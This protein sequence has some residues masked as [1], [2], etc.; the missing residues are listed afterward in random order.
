MLL[1]LHHIAADGWSLGPLGRDLAR[2]YAAR[3]QGAEPQLPALAVQYADYT[4]WQQQVLGSETDPESPLGGQIAFW[5]KALEGLPEQLELPTD[6]PR[7]A[8][9]SYRGETVPLQLGSELHGRLLVLAREHQVSLF[10][11][12]QAALATLL[13]RLGAG[14]DIPIGCPIAGRTDFALEELVGFFVNTLVLRTDTSANPSFRE[15]LARVRSA[16]LAA[17]AHQELPFERLVELLNPA[18]SL[19]RHPLFQVMLAFQNTPEI[20]FE[21]PGIVASLEPVDINVAK[22]DLCFSLGERRAPDGM[23]EGIEG[24][25]EYR[26]DLFERRT[27]EALARR[28]E[29]LLEAVTADP[30]QRIGRLELLGSEERRQILLERNDTACEIPPGT[31]PALFE[32]E[33][34]RSPEATAL[35][36]EE[37]TLTYAQLNTQSNRLAHLLIARGI[38][39]ETIVALVLPRSAEMV[40]GLLAILKAGAAYLPLDPDDPAER[41]AYMLR[42]AQAACVLTTA[43]IAQRLPERVALILLDHPETVGVLLRSQETNPS[44]AERTNSLN[45]NNAAYVIYTSGSTGVPKGVVITHGG[46][47]NYAAWALQAYGLGVGSGAPINTPLAFDATVT[48]LFLPLLSG[49]PITLLPELR[50]FEVLAEEPRYSARFSLLKLTPAH[51]EVLNHLMPDKSLEGLTHCLVIGGESLS[52]LTV[53]RWRRHAPQTRLINEYGPTETAVGC[54]IYEVQPTDPEGGTIPIGR[55]IWN[56]RVYVLDGNLQPVPAGVAGELCIAGAG[57]ARGYLNRPGL[58]AERFVADPFGAPGHRMYRT[59]DLARWRADGVLEFLGRGDQQLKIRGFR[60]EPG[61]IE[62]ALVRHTGVTQAAVIAREDHAGDKRLVGYVVTKPAQSLDRGELRAYLSRVLPDYMVPAVF[63]E[64][65]ALPLTPNGKL[66]RKALP[67]PDFAVLKGRWRAPRSPEEEILCALFSEVLGVSGVGIED[68]FFVLG[69]HSLLATRLISRIRTTLEIELPIRTLFETPTVCGVARSLQASQ[70]AR[71]GLEALPRPAQIPLSFAQRRLWFIDRLEGP[72]PTYNIPLALRLRGRLDFAA[73]KAAL[74]DVVRR[75]ESLRT[76][77]TELGGTPYQRILEPASAEPGL[78]VVPATEG[79]LARGL[80]EAARY[81]FDLGTEIPLRASLFTLEHDEQVLLL[82]VHHIAADGWSMVPLVRDLAQA[83]MARC[84]SKA[85]ELRPLVVQYADYTLWQQ[86]TLGDESDSHS[87]LG[88]QLAYW[89]QTLQALPEQLD[90]PTDRPRPAIASYRGRWVPLNLSPEL[91]SRLLT[92]AYKNQSSLFMVLQAGVSVLLTRLGAGTDIP[93]GTPIAGRTDIGLEE[94]VGFFVNTLVLRTDTSANPS[95]RQL[96]A[97]VRATDLGAYAH[98][99]LP[100]E[101]L[102]ELLNPARSLSRHPLF[103]VMLAFQ[104]NSEPTLELPGIFT[105]SEAVNIDAARFDLT[106]ELTERRA[107]DGTPEGIE[108]A[109]EYRTDLFEGS[110]VQAIAE[111][112]VRLLERAAAEPDRPIGQ[113]DI[114]NPKERQQLLVQWNNTEQPVAK[115]TLSSLFEAQVARSP[116]EPALLFE[117]ITLSYAELNLQANQLAHYLISQGVGPETVVAIALPRSIEMVVGLLAILKAGGAYLPLDSDYPPE[118]LG[119][120]LEDAQPACVLTTSQ[121]VELLPGEFAQLLVDQPGTR[122]KL[123]EQPETN[124]TDAQRTAPLQPL[125]PAYVIYTSGSTGTPKGVVVTHDGIPSLTAAQIDQF[126]LTPEARVLQFASLS[127]DVVLSEVAM[128]LLSGATLVLAGPQ[129]RSAEPLTAL[130]QRQKVTHAA[131]TPS[132]LASLDQELPLLRSLLVGG[133]PCSPDLV[134]QWSEG[135]RMVNVYGPTETTVCATISAPLSGAIVPPIGRPIWNTRAYVLDTNLQPVPAGVTGELYIAGAGLARGYLNRP[136]L[137]AERFVADPYGPPRTRMYRTGDL[138]RWRADGVLEFLGRADRQLKIRGFRIEPR[139]IEAALLRHPGVAQA[140]VIAREDRAG[141]KR[142]VAYVVSKTAQSLDRAELRTYLAGTLPDYM[143]PAAFVVLEA[144]PLTPN[145]KLD[146]KALPASDLAAAKGCWRA[147]RSHQEEILCALFAEILGV[148]RVSIDSN[149]FELGGHSLLATRLISRIRMRFGADL[150]I[151]CL[152]E[153]P[154]VAGLA[155]RLHAVND[156]NPLDVLLPLRP[157]GASRPLFCI[158]P[159]GGLSWA[160]S[161]LIPFLKPDHPLYGLQA[162]G[163]AHPDALPCTLEEMASDYLD[164]IRGIQPGGPYLLLGWSFG[165]LVAY[166]IATQLQSQGEYGTF[167]VLLDSYPTDQ[168]FSPHIPDD[169]ELLADLLKEADTDPKSLEAVKESTPHAQFQER[170][171][172][173]RHLPTTISE[174][175]IAAMMKVYKHN[176]ILASKFVPR[177][178]DGDLLLFIASHNATEPRQ[179]I[180]TTYAKRRIR[181]YEIA[182]EHANMLEPGPLG[183]IAS[184]LA[185]ELKR[186]TNGRE[187]S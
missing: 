72:S 154:T 185:L 186:R 77:F 80:S 39:P 58:S 14:S 163:I 115:T 65:E 3:A 127:F 36:F 146:R 68:N 153:A 7:P 11:V 145:G 108:G 134:A 176:I 181:S 123:K 17:Y 55:P 117:E 57:L 81:C 25:I 103:Q 135:R 151:R 156:Q 16:D 37:A 168:Q 159:A 177:C 132:V 182:C 91:H 133:E 96:L 95:F 187:E 51:I 104:N 18:R 83:Y 40:V 100:F 6:W 172:R 87:A 31:L 128:S 67:A 90:L 42:D 50:Q 97:R 43:R 75:H 165:G 93:I 24:A 139:E 137:T 184:L 171:L 169:R 121:L 63:V 148:P 106:F 52:E 2:A 41:L 155:T 98:Q 125:H 78:E 157:H 116:Q 158:H 5:T 69:G 26:T 113:L 150:S 119:Y 183:E 10:M 178:F 174:Y 126:A 149:F 46:V 64:L 109:I 179:R 130:I 49:K 47:I 62:A 21:L 143:V 147:P 19:S 136:G 124:P 73:L 152:F 86:Q 1:V 56:T 23:A 27:I 142:L 22:F 53:D 48:S 141:D 82:L 107:P 60:I 112:L 33:V 4:L 71:P 28:L 88:H 140:A 111:R 118:R 35:L 138:A 15:L 20:E 131:L 70:S 101:R 167:L 173:K 66:D 45:P 89:K 122:R 85:P 144:L 38:G 166:E 175:Q 30:G 120:M 110:S 32:A 59:G 99:E 160:Y 84:Q 79:T 76:I 180:W 94:L 74:G 9:A 12:L 105:S 13:S 162:R 92:L 114:L 8:I 61:E 129:E 44:D 170:P 164:Q 102:V 161:K 29:R 34:K 54:T